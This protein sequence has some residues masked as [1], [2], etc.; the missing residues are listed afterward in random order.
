LSC[1]YVPDSRRAS[2]RGW[3]DLVILGRRVLFRELKTE[4]GVV[5]AEQYEIGA[6][7]LW[8][9]QSWAIWRPHDLRSGRIL[10]QLADI[11]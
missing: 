9:G 8:A 4:Y 6:K 10:R 11:C 3:P 1:Y 5:S 7:L 2:V